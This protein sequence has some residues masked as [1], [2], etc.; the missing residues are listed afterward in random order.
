MI[1]N[2]IACAVAGLIFIQPITT[3]TTTT[4]EA[5]IPSETP[6]E[7]KI[8]KPIEDYPLHL[9]EILEEP[10]VV[11]EKVLKTSKVVIPSGEYPVA[12]EIWNYLKDLGYNDYVCAGILGNMMAE[13]G[14]QTLDIQYWLYNPSGDYYGCCQWSMYYFPEIGG[15]DLK[16][17]L[18]FLRDT[19]KLNIDM[20]GN[21]YQQGF[22]YDKFL[23]LADERAAALAFADCYERGAPQYNHC[24]I[25]S[26]TIAYNYFVK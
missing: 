12:T 7:R 8:L 19:I 2:F 3:I 20:F 5:Y 25:N 22:N 23:T 24:R 11:E 17:Q 13:V 26:A 9:P 18:D 1:N 16:T 10:P 6:I 14:G 4:S 21:N 15:A